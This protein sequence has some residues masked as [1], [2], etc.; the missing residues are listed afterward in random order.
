MLEKINFTLIYLFIYFVLWICTMVLWYQ[1]LLICIYYRTPENLS[2]NSKVPGNPS[3]ELLVIR[4]MIE[5]KD[6][7]ILSYLHLKVIFWK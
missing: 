7:N 2:I 5:Q 3:W 1:T 4:D 6:Q